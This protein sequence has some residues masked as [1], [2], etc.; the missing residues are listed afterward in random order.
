MKHGTDSSEPVPEPVERSDREAHAPLRTPLALEVGRILLSAGAGLALAHPAIAQVPRS[1]A[2]DSDSGQL[3]EIVVR[4][5]RRESPLLDHSALSKLSQNLLDTPQSIK[6]LSRELLDDRGATNLNDALQNVP[7]ITLGA[8][9]FRWQGNAP[10][11][12][13]FRA[14]DDMYLDGLRDFG[15]Y[16]RDPFALETIEVLLGPSSMLFGRG[17]TGGAINQVMKRPVG[18]A[19]TELSLNAG[20][21]DTLRATVDVSRP[22]PLLGDGAAFRLN[23]LAH[24]AKASGRDGGETE[25]FG[26]APSLALDFGSATQLTLSLLA[27]RSDDQPDYGLPWLNGAPAPVTRRNYYGFSDDYLKTDADVGTVHVTH[28]VGASIN[29]DAKV[30]YADYTRHSRITEPLITQTVLPGTPLG[31]VSVYRNVFLGHSKETFLTGETTVTMHLMTGQIRHDLVAGAESTRETSAPTFGWAV[32]VREANLLHP[33]TA[34]TY[35][36]SFDAPRLTAYTQSFTRALYAVDTLKLGDAWQVTVGVRHDRFDTD[37][38]AERYPG[39]PTPFNAG[40]QSGP[41]S[42]G[43]VDD[44]T[45][46]RVGVVYKLSDGASVYFAGSTAFTP[47]GEE[48]SFI[49]GGRTLAVSNISRDPEK[50]RGVEVGVKSNIAEGRLSLTGAL[51]EITKVNARVPDP[52]NPGF[53]ILAGKQRARG[54][55]IEAQGT[56]TER[57]YLSSGYTY[58]DTAVVRGAPGAAAGAPLE[59]APRHSLSIWTDYQATR[60]F[61]FGIGARYVST[62]LGDNR[63]G[64]KRVPGY[65]VFDAMAR[66][67]QSPRLALKLNLNNLTDE[68][69]FEQLHRYHVVPGPGMTATFAATLDF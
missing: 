31:D 3:E 22:V 23:A 16:P 53:N 36:A 66:Y 15:S 58:L 63:G 39:P 7:G 30:R 46:Y 25:R 43:Q 4:D 48:V 37:Y 28:A 2:G 44:V 34:D 24:R 41:E 21:P 54:L 62:A 59:A 68:Y 27:Q 65:R 29:L 32:G 45:S 52:A 17:S 61:D 5:T 12:R 6:T 42:F 56:I 38:H 60:R 18:D 20:S 8:G 57:L 13:G 67:Q 14:R 35:S 26:L 69:Y 33:D 47:A 10:S 19:L 64:G 1:P 55:S 40:D 9:E 51:F 49:S 11:I 50:N